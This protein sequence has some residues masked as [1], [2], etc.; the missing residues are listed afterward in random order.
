VRAQL[1]DALWEARDWAARAADLETLV[2]LAIDTGD[3]GKRMRGML[4]NGGVRAETLAELQ[5]SAS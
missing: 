5:S 2:R 3:I 4:A 1:I